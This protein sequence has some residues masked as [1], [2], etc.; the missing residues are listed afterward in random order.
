[1][2]SPRHLHLT[3]VKRIIWYL[4][5]T[6]TRG[7]YY[8]KDNHLQLTTYA[9]ADWAG[10]QDTPQSTTGWCMYLGD[11]L[12][13]WKCKKKERVSRSSTEAEYRA[14]SSACSEI[15]WIQVL[16][17][18]LKVAQSSPTSLHADNNGAIRITENPIFHERTK[19]IE[20]DCHFIRGEYKCDVISL[21]HVPTE[22]QLLISSPKD[23]LGHDISFWFPNCCSMT[24]QHQFDGG[25][26]IQAQSCRPI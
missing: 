6:V 22:L 18:E 13:S 19:H 26:S 20:V 17:S 12:I 25:V 9:D 8:P 3:A 23:F 15:L 1:M 4:L 21:P 16:L 24:P 11:S 10:C 2:T 14:M 7:L 5:G